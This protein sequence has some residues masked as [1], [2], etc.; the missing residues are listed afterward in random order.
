M[1]IAFMGDG[2]LNH[3]RRW[4]GF[5]HL[6][7]HQVIL[8]SFEPVPPTDFRTVRIRAG[9]PTKLISYLSSLSRVR[10]ILH[11]FRPDLV[12]TLYLGGYG[13]LGT[14]AGYRP[15]AVSA[16]GSDLLVDYQKHLIHRLQIKRVLRNADLIITD[17][18]NLSR[19]AI[20]IGAQ[21]DKIIKIYLGIDRTLFHP[22]AHTPSRQ[23][24]EGHF[25]IISTRNFYPVY[26]LSTLVRAASLVVDKVE[27]RF[28]LCG[29]GPERGDLK[30]EV[31]SRGLKDFFDFKGK[32]AP[33]GIAAQLGDSSVY[34]STSVSDSTSVSLLEA[35]ACGV[36]PVVTDIQANREWI[37][38]GKNGLLFPPRHP[39]R[40]AESILKLYHNRKI[41]QGFREE[42]DRIIQER[43]LWEDNMKKAERA[44][45]GL[46]EKERNG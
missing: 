7:D 12:S 8:I 16:L 13:L 2:S 3:V 21:P 36:A 18:E 6:R 4:V 22:P 27:A 25:R 32:L 26:D 34:V 29:D 17:A 14:L 15:L 31:K 38:D 33:P 10:E 20:S 39:P 11:S 35:M 44:F 30:E 46:V 42:N 23:K 24:E 37:E 19:R 28:V 5:F 9:L 1:R 41:I 40:L 45:N 43:G